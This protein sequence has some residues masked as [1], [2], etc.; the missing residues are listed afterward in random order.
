M[1]GKRYIC[2][3][4]L[5]VGIASLTGTQARGAVSRT[6]ASSLRSMLVRLNADCLK[7]DRRRP[8]TCNVYLKKGAQ[9]GVAGEAAAICDLFVPVR[10]SSS[11]YLSFVGITATPKSIALGCAWS[12]SWS[13]AL[14]AP[15]AVDFKLPIRSSLSVPACSVYQGAQC[16]SMGQGGMMVNWDY[17]TSFNPGFRFNA[18][19][20]QAG[21]QR[22]TQS[23]SALVKYYVPD[24]KQ[25]ERMGK[26]LGLPVSG[27]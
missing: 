25:V 23:P 8:A 2:V 27:K 15:V 13:D 6:E 10:P 4:A 24:W 12:R 18:P 14:S 7:A 11:D 19:Q 26:A 22:Q 9:R 21:I 20:G 5:L 16:S 1:P 3:G 17:G